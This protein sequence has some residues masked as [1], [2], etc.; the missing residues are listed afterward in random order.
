M[1]WLALGE[2]IF[3]VALWSTSP[4]LVKIA[5]GYL[6]PLQLAGVRYFG[7]FL[8]LLPLLLWRSM[9]VLRGLTRSAWLRLALMGFLAFP[10]GNGLLFWGLE[11]LPATTSS[12]LLTS[13]PIFTLVIG[14]LWLKERPNWIQGI[15]FLLAITGGLIFFGMRIEASDGLAV[16]AT[17]LG[18]LSLS[19]FGSMARDFVRKGEVNSTVL[20]AIPM[21]I[22]GG[23][24]LI[25]APVTQ[26]PPMPA[27]G[28]LVILAIVNSALAFMIWN[29][30]LQ[31]L[32]AFEIS[33][34]GNLMPI[35]TAL[36]APLLLGEVISGRAWLGMAVALAGV[37]LVGIAGDRKSHAADGCVESVVS[38]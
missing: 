1:R 28:I 9:N 30:A 16:L 33:I 7:A 4:P 32:Q 24:L 35:G 36:V 31:S 27:L 25:I 26:V 14:I 11:T 3:V 13:I 22:G 15:G 10:V 12:F 5:L 6:S 2:A 20:A 8:I 34:V 29:H 38:E 23:M 17:V 19:V 21:C 37:I 18:S